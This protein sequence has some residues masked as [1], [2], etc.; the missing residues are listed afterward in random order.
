[1]EEKL[2]LDERDLIC[3]A[4]NMDK[5]KFD[6]YIDQLD[7]IIE[8][9]SVNTGLTK[10]KFINSSKKY[11]VDENFNFTVFFFLQYIAICKRECYGYKYNKNMFVNDMINITGILCA[12]VYG[13]DKF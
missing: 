3:L 5:D 10:D 12:N 9:I 13:L 7:D 1:M 11:F 2:K 4:I 6:D 8:E